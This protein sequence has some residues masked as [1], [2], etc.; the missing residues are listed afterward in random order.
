MESKSIEFTNWSGQYTSL[1]AA[2]VS[3]ETPE[4]LQEIIKN[5][6]HYPSPLVAL[7]SGHSDSGCNV[8]YGGTAVSMKK[9]HYIYEPTDNDVIAGAGIELIEL[10]RYLAQRNKQIPFTP[11]IGNATLGSVA[12]CCLKDASIGQSSGL[13]T[14]MVKAIKYIDAFG[15]KQYIQRGEE[16]WQMM[17]SSHGLFCIIYEVTLDVIPMQLVIQNYVSTKKKSSLCSAFY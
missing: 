12:C 1:A 7:G 10:H 15:N 14:Y 6:E 8:V 17:T 13:A 11:E 3:P 2:Y 4:Q 9:F 5:K 16:G